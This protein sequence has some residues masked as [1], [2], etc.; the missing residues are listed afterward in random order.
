MLAP[1]TC[2]QCNTAGVLAPTKG[3][4][5]NTAGV[6]APT[7]GGQC[8]TAGVLASTKGGICNKAGVQAPTKGGICIWLECWYSTNGLKVRTT[9]VRDSIVVVAEWVMRIAK[10]AL[11][12]IAKQIYHSTVKMKLL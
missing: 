8:N 7:K 5:C 4:Q 6:L 1:T 3:G 11:F 10:L 9:T 2:G 12:E